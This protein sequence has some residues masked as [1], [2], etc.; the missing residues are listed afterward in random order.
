MFAD[1]RIIEYVKKSYG[2]DLE[3]LWKKTPDAAIW[4]RKDSK[5]W[6]GIIMCIPKNK[7]IKN[8]KGNAEIMNV[9]LSCSDIEK[10][11]DSKNYFPAYHMNKKYWLSMILDDRLSDVD[12]FSKI[13]SS[14]ALASNKKSR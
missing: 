1:K 9:K 8:A 14:Y 13:N 11:V 7:L 5:K 3:F 2:D 6:Y 4:R 10:F 12:I